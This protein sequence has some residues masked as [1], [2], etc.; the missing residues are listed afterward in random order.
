MSGIPTSPM[1]VEGVQHLAQRAYRESGELHY[2]REFYFS[3]TKAEQF[4][5]DSARV[6][7][8]KAA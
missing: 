1:R 6:R 5:R 8:R 4:V 7:Q 3:A 2:W